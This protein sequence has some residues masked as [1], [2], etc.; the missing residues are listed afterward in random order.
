MGSANAS[1]PQQHLIVTDR[2]RLIPLPVSVYSALLN[3]QKHEA[4]R[5]LGLSLD[6]GRLADLAPI[7]RHRYDQLQQDPAQTAWLIR[8]MV[9][10]CRS[11]VVGDIGFHAPPDATGMVEI[12][13]TVIESYRGQGF[14][15]EAS[16]AL[17]RWAA[18]QPRVR[19]LRAS[20][21]PGNAASLR[22]AQKLGLVAIGRQMDEIDGEEIVFEGPIGP[23]TQAYSS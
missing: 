20:I 22:I 19:R 8:L 2:L 14:A 23:L 16:F 17:A 18:T 15:T 7:V 6:E 11:T 21:S 10:R 3:G 9:L 12:G 13:Y 1:D 4:E 5:I